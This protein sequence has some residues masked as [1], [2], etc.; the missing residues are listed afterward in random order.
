[1]IKFKC[2]KIIL[3]KSVK[4]SFFLVLIIC[5]SCRTN[6]T[7]NAP[8]NKHVK[9]KS[10]GQYFSIAE[11]RSYQA[12]K[13]GSTFILQLDSERKVTPDSIITDRNIGLIDIRPTNDPFKFEC[14][15]KSKHFGRLSQPVKVLFSD[16]LQENHTL[17]ILHLPNNEPEQLSF[18]VI[19]RIPHDSEAYTQ[20]L[21]FKNDVLY[22]STG[23]YGRSS[24]RAINPVSGEII[25]KKSLESKYFGEGI[26]IF[27]NEIYMLTYKAGVGFVFDISTFDLL[28]EF[29]LQTEEGWGLAINN[30]SIIM[31]DGSEVLYYFRP[32]DYF[33]LLGQIEVCTNQGFVNNLN[34]LEMSPEGLFANVYGSNLIYKIDIDKGLVTNILDLS[35]L[36]PDNVPKDMD[37]VLNG[38]AYNQKKETYYITGKQ[39]PIMYEIKILSN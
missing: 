7:N 14:S 5:F 20:G 2:F 4:Y 18:K 26:T 28:R 38:I 23:Q 37:H 16:S 13:S 15:I 21:I 31:S 9:S 24:L 30:D 25:R 8:L 6:K 27:N 35:E 10:T 39:W 29:Q 3:P 22:E 11:P 34:E 36:F 19:R 1:M 17:K 12:V 33:T 32:D